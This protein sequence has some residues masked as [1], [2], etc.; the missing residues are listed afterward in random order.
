MKEVLRSQDGSH[1]L[2][3]MELVI[4]DDGKPRVTAACKE[5]LAELG[6]AVFTDSRGNDILFKP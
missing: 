4:G 5:R 3:D 6:Y 1:Y 2:V